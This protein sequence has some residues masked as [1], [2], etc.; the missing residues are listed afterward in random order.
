MN[1][2]MKMIWRRLT[3]DSRRFSLFCTLLF[4]GLLLWARIIVIARPPRTAVAETVAETVSVILASS[5]KVSV[6]VVLESK[7]IKNPFTINAFAYPEIVVGTDNTTFQYRK[8]TIKSEQALVD[9]LELE[10]IMGEMAMINGRVVQKG[11]VVV[12]QNV[13][14]PLRLTELSGR[15]VIISAGERRYELTIAPLRH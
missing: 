9:G 10:A 4:V 7:P 8:N 3:A 5:D 13:P 1:K 6:P 15:S 12:A 14:I 2:K 11:D